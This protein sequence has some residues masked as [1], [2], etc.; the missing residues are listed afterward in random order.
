MK[1]RI[2]LPWLLA[3]ALGTAPLAVGCD[4]LAR[5]AERGAGGAA[6]GA[7]LGSAQ[8]PLVVRVKRHDDQVRP[9]P[10]GRWRLRPEADLS[11]VTLWFS[12]ILV[13]HA[14]VTPAVVSFHPPFWRSAPPA[15][16]RSRAD[17]LTLAREVG[18]HA[19]AHPEQFAELAAE[20]SE[21]LASR[22]LG[23]DVG[24]ASA[25]AIAMDVPEVVDALAALPLGAVSEVVETKY[26]FHVL[27]RGARPAPERVSAA[28]IVVAHE[29]A[30]ELRFSAARQQPPP[31]RSRDAA[32]DIAR[33]VRAEAVAAPAS[34]AALAAG[35]SDHIDAASGGDLG[36]WSTAEPGGLRRISAIV[37]RL[38]PGE[39]SE[40]FD[41]PHGIQ[42][43]QRSELRPRRRFAFTGIRVRPEGPAGK[44]EAARLA[45]ALAAR[46]RAAPSGFASLQAE[47]CCRLD[48]HWVEGHGSVAAA[49]LLDQL[50][51]GEVTPAATW[52]QE[53]GGYVVLQKLDPA[54]VSWNE[55]ET[56]SELPAPEEPDL[57]YLASSKLSALEVRDVLR[58]VGIRAAAALVLSPARA[59]AFQAL[60]DLSG[61]F[62][63][64][65]T[66]TKERARL[67]NDFRQ[68]VAAFLGAEDDSRY[69]RI[70]YDELERVVLDPRRS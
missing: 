2:E 13:R 26:G 52:L 51:V 45:D 66:H 10:P 56:S 41:S 24:G 43:V 18:N 16:E 15:P 54:G 32:F 14:E 61:A 47:H 69:A 48:R 11:T 64:S 42:I 35:Y 31:A 17:A 63:E 9:Y 65:V 58:A 6:Q 46:G 57:G 70:L 28:H 7:E 53:L 20:Y 49:A 67:I 29:A 40:P 33:Q 21:D 23:G 4:V 59:G 1:R 27:R 44:A 55:P 3:F 30:L 36:E 39:V 50:A 34:F 68:R 38:A 12:H 62:E 37:S 19:A 8:N 22:D 25:R 60:H 5:R